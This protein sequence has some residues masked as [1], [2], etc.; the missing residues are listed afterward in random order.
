MTS[1]GRMGGK[2]NGGEGEIQKK[3]N[4][5]NPPNG[6]GMPHQSPLAP[7]LLPL[8]VTRWGS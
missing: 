8:L 2:G 4:P 7:T 6:Q 3:V 1:R 5:H